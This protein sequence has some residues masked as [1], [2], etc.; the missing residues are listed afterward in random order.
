[1]IAIAR[2]RACVL[3]LVVVVGCGHDTRVTDDAASPTAIAVQ[4]GSIGVTVSAFAPGIVKLHYSALDATARPSW[5]VVLPSPPVEVGAG[6]TL[7]TPELRVDVDAQCRVRATLADGTV[8]IADAEP[9]SIADN[10]VLSRTPSADRVYGLGERTG[11]LDKRGRAWTFWNTDAYDPTVGGWHPGQDPLYQSIPFELHQRGAVTFG[12][13]TDA[14]RRM[15]IDLEGA[16][17]RVIVDG[18]RSIEQ[19]VIAGPRMANVVDRYTQLTGRPTL[20]PRWA[21]GFHQS[22]WGYNSADQLEAIAAKYR[23]LDIPADA[24]WLDIQHMRGFRSFTFDPATFGDPAALISRLSARG[25]RVITI[26]DPGIKVDPGWDVY[27][28]GQPHFL[29]FIGNAWPGASKWPDFSSAAARAWWGAQISRTLDVGIAGIWLDV[30]EPTTFPEGGGGTSIPDTVAVD[31]D[32]VPTTMAE[33]HNVYALLQA[34]ATYDAIAARGKR[35]FV[36]SR[37][38]YAGIQRYAAVWTG[39]T[40]STWQGLQQTLPML[41][42]LGMSGVPIVGSDVGGYSGHATPELYA[43]WFALGSISPFSRAHV[44]SN[45][46]GQEPWMFGAEVLRASRDQLAERYHLLPYLYSLADEAART[47]APLL[48][49]LVWEFPEDEAVANMD[50]EAMLGASILVAPAV[51]QGA[52]TRS[53]YLPAG[54]WY[55][56]ASDVFFD[57]PTT[58]TLPLRLASLPMFVREGAI[59]PTSDGID[60]YPGSGQLTLYEDDGETGANATRTQITMTARANGID[61]TASKPLTFRVHR[62][63]HGYDENARIATVTGARVSLT[64]ERATEPAPMVEVPIEVHVPSGPVY[65]AASTNN[66]THVPLTVSGNVARGTITAKRGE[67]IDYKITRGSWDSV[68]KLADCSE[69]PN[70]TRI[71]SHK[72]VID[73]VEAWRDGCAHE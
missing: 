33:L 61:L 57:G 52:T 48:R 5:A 40:P 12:I 7:E 4:C 24:L 69:A 38:G 37:A 73:R 18:A 11:G 22:R 47:G 41:L 59:I 29:D 35:P 58:I 16:R 55:D 13:F 6:T 26:E 23:E 60:V 32:G 45:V 20:P 39:D 43:R 10:A 51:E 27:D 68:E 71:A 50:D 62:V 14:T 28:S 25:F 63:D 3:A 17:D 2:V 46:P 56:Y 30:N 34:R 70:R 66:W 64:F 9:F 65:I 31:G 19:Y 53:V 67:W 8:A 42:G 15:T 72:L 36:L 1:L 21:L 44:T 54:R 49:P